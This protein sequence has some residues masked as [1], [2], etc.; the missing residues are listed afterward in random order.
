MRQLVL[1]RIDQEIKHH[2]RDGNGHLVFKMNALTDK[3]CIQA[4][5]RASQA[6]VKVDLQ[7][8]GMCCLRPGVPGVSENIKVTSIVGRFLEHARIYYFRNGGQEEILLGSAD[9]MPR[10]LDRRVEILFPVQDE[11][12][13]EVIRRDILLVHLKD[14]VKSR[15]LL[16]EGRYERIRPQ[17]GEPALDSQQWMLEHRGSWNSGD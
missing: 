7:V 14:N 8:R 11:R 9:L 5:Y 15:Q 6:G 12:L 4:L 16:A 10:N 17:P 2:R 3:P 13:R 1:Q